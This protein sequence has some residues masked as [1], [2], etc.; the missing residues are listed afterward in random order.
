MPAL[1]PQN[2][3]DLVV[4]VARNTVPCVQGALIPQLRLITAP[5]SPVIVVFVV[6]SPAIIGEQC[7]EVV[8]A[9]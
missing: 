8:T 3:T 1:Q 2:P 5:V 9:G 7:V 4:T 6:I